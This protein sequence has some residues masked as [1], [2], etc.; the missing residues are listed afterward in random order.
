MPKG[1]MDARGVFGLEMKILR[2]RVY[3]DSLSEQSQYTRLFYIITGRTC[4]VSVTFP[5]GI[6]MVSP[7]QG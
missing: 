6:D 1:F 4:S 7:E 3:T 5:P 2:D